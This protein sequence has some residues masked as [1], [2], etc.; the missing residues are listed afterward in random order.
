MPIMKDKPST[1]NSERERF[2]K[3]SPPIFG[4][5]KLGGKG[6]KVLFEI[7]SKIARVEPNAGKT[8]IKMQIKIKFDESRKDINVLVD[9]VS[10]ENIIPR[11]LCMKVG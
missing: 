7:E 10:L 5:S 2:G 4:Y 9:T 8:Q 1:S 3:P 11:E 6:H